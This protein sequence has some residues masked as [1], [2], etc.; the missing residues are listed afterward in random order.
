MR[1]RSGFRGQ[2]YRYQPTQIA[3]TQLHIEK[4]VRYSSRMKSLLLNLV[5]FTVG[6][7]LLAVFV[8]YNLTPSAVF[9]PSPHWIGLAHLPSTIVGGLLG[10]VFVWC[11]SIRAKTA[12]K[13]QNKRLGLIVSMIAVALCGYATGK[14][15]SGFGAQFLTGDEREY[16]TISTFVRS[17]YSSSG[18]S[19]VGWRLAYGHRLP[20]RQ[21]SL[22]VCV[23][24]GSR[25][26]LVGRGS[27]FGLYIDKVTITDRVHEDQMTLNLVEETI[28]LPQRCA[29][30]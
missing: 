29:G 4:H 18:R 28:Q 8:G 27:R 12:G 20:V 2:T 19:E 5:M 7:I 6:L 15:V 26:E 14:V 22:Y 17:K 10:A 16:Q 30:Q 3:G 1:L 13:T 25:I 23:S 24:P 21:S 9:L 11:L